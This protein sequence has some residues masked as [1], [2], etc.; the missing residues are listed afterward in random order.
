MITS[1]FARGISTSAITRDDAAPTDDDTV[2]ELYA[3]LFAAI[4]SD[5]ALTEAV[6]LG[7]AMGPGMGVPLFARH[8]SLLGGPTALWMGALYSRYVLG[9]YLSLEGAVRLIGPQHFNDFLN[10]PH[11][12]ARRTDASLWVT[13]FEAGLRY[14]P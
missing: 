8:D 9:H 5:W 2:R 3:R 11:S 12:P 10:E 14:S 4:G 13:S 7:V 1:F 6:R